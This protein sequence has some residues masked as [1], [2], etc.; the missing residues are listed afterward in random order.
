MATASALETGLAS[1]VGAARV[2]TEESACQAF[3]AD[4]VRP[5]C[6]VYPPG[7]AEAA[8]VLAYCAEHALTVIPCRNGT[9][10]AV[11][12]APRRYDVALNV[13]ELNR[14]WHYEPADLTVSVEP[15]M[16][17]GDFQH[18][19]SRHGLWLPLDP[20]G[21]AKAS[22]GGILATNSTG[23]LRFC[24]GAP[25]DMVLGLKI[26]TGEGKIVKTGGRV[27]KNVTGYDLAKL[28]V[29]SYGTL[30]VIV[31]ASFKLFPRP[32]ERAT[33]ALRPG[34][35]GIARELRRGVLAS[36]LTPMRMALLNSRA[37]ALAR[38][39]T[40]LAAAPGGPEVWIEFGG[41]KRVLARCESEIGQ[42]GKA[43]GAPPERIDEETAKKVWERVADFRGWL[44]GSSPQPVVL[45][46]ALPDSAS[47]EF[48]SL[49]EQQA[50]N[51][52]VP[53]AAVSLMGVG[54]AR[55]ALLET[56]AAEAAQRLV[57]R[58][59]AGVESLR[60]AVVLEAAPPELKARVEAWGKAGEDLELMKRVKSVWDP[61][62]ILSPGRFV[63][64]L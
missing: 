31:E 19:V 56:P 3:A 10:L 30:G 27:V 11:G 29:G 17:F 18:F 7:A 1:L 52:K 8:A 41:S 60:G 37:A 54:I 34:T 5:K 32:V 24:Y 43:V 14:V 36:P 51:E 20:P 53:L 45:K 6:V 38:T 39:G 40:A 9:K 42:L 47:E 63:G 50:E 21:G 59:R 22:L 46:A 16:K 23:P 35:L 49:A 2:V 26:A 12:N 55:L 33:F 44:A 13:K 57:E 15:G 48:M 62:G 4:G 28:L 25:R 61:K 64:N 58:L